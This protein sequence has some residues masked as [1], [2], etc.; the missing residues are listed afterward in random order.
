MLS[1]LADQRDAFL[2]WFT[3]KSSPGSLIPTS[4][5]KKIMSRVGVWLGDSRNPYTVNTKGSLFRLL[6]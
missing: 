2:T 5:F 1:Y 3:T 4:S 6:A